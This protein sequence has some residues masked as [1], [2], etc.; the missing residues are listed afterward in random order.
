MRQMPSRFNAFRRL[1]W[2]HRPETVELK[3]LSDDGLAGFVCFV[4][5]PQLLIPFQRSSR[6]PAKK[7]TGLESLSTDSAL[8]RS[9]GLEAP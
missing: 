3:L 9:A 1:P 6:S 4:F 8:D 2:I 5:R 7:M